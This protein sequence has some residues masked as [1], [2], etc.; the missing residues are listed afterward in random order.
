MFLDITQS[1]YY[2]SPTRRY[3]QVRGK[4]RCSHQRSNN[5]LKF[6]GNFY[7]TSGKKKAQRYAA[8]EVILLMSYWNKSPPPVIATDWFAAYKSGLIQ[9][10]SSL[11]TELIT[12][13]GRAHQHPHLLLCNISEK[14]KC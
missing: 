9:V 4:T 2:K 5:L 11:L 7:L 1:S 10:V 14:N 3:W 12:S 8:V 6:K 13:M